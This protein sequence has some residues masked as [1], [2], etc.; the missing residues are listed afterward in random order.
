MTNVNSDSFSLRRSVCGAL[1]IVAVTGFA[2]RIL[3]AARLFDPSRYRDETKTAEEDPRSKWPPARPV[4]MLSF[5]DNDRSRWDTVRGLVDQHTYAIGHREAGSGTNHYK[6]TGIIT[7]DGW[8]TIDKVLRPDTHDFYSSK[9]PFLATLAAGEYWLLKQLYGWSIVDPGWHVMRVIL[10]TLNALPFALYLWLLA[11]LLDQQGQT[12]W[13]RFFVFAAACFATLVTPFAVTFNNHTV[14]T[15]T[16]LFALY[17]ALQICSGRQ[18][19]SGLFLAAGFFAGFTAACELPATALISILFMVLVI[20]APARTLLL[21]LPAAAIP[22]AAFLW[23]NYL[24]LGELSPA[25]EKFGTPWYE[26]EGSHW[27]IDPAL[28]QHGIDWAYLSEGRAAYAFHMLVGHHGVF[29]LTPIYLLSVAG[30]IYGLFHWNRSSR[31]AAGLRETALVSLILSIVVICFYV[32]G[33]PERNRNYG[34]W[35]CGLRWLMWLTPF[36][37]LAMVPAADWLS[38]RRWGRWLA[39]LFLAISVFSATYPA[40]NPWRHPWLYDWMEAQGWIRY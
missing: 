32:F 40:R 10:L 33:V 12:E 38:S 30:M 15:Y 25:Y 19:T 37:L 13:G 22:I 2:A 3:T 29:S 21:Y 14:A 28:P 6:D 39:Y 8:Q 36:W 23:T 1:I 20:R 7:E 26:Y 35:A 18:Q 24:A 34:G 4:P 27:K 31:P 11:R 16:A 9:P 5:G 17:P